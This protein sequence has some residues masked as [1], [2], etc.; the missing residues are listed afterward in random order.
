MLNKVARLLELVVERNDGLGAHGR[1]QRQHLRAA[2]A[3]LAAVDAGPFAQVV[4]VGLAL[5][6]ERFLQPLERIEALGG[7]IVV[8]PVQ[9]PDGRRFAWLTDPD[10]NTIGII[11]PLL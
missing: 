2:A 4:D 3:A 1:A 10:G 7:S 8:P 5:L 9:L 6:E 11:T